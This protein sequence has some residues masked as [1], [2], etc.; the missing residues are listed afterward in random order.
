ME[1]APLTEVHNGYEA[2]SELVAVRLTH[3]SDVEPET[4]AWL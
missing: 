3:M 2:P 4:V 1:H